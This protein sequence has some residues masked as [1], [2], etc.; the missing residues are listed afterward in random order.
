[1]KAWHFLHDN[2]LLRDGTD[3]PA[4]GQWL[5]YPGKREMCKSGLHAS[6]KPLDALKYAPG[7]IVCR[8]EVDKACIITWHH[9]INTRRR[10]ILW[11][12]DTIEILSHF[13]RLCAL[14]VIHLWDAPD[15]VIKYLRTG[16]KSRREAARSAARDTVSTVFNA[17]SSAAGFATAKYIGYA[18]ANAAAGAASSAIGLAAGRAAGCSAIFAASSDV[19]SDTGMAAGCA[20]ALATCKAANRAA[21]C[22]T[23]RF[24]ARDAALAAQNKRLHRML[25]KANSK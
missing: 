17:A 6:I 24:A 21:G 18:T 20:T 13:S 15:V 10:K 19:P 12:L 23:V 14:D 4:D 9:K 8:V 25:T 7:S 22:A 16:D 5:E 1:M 3:P 2:G 11:R